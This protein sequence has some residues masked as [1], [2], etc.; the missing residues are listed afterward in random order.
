MWTEHNIA[1]VPG[2]STVA[3]IQLP[4]MLDLSMIF[5]FASEFFGLTPVK[6]FKVGNGESARNSAESYIYKPE[7]ATE[8][9][10]SANPSP[11]QRQTSQILMSHQLSHYPCHPTITETLRPV[12]LQ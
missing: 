3:M 5:E 10:T 7:A 8:S 4:L 12:T 9:I 2:N 1:E 6:L 11:P